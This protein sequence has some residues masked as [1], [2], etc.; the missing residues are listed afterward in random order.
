MM[1]RMAS[2]SLLREGNKG[3]V[4]ERDNQQLIIEE[5]SVV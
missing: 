1:L 4:E 5:V 2:E 3:K